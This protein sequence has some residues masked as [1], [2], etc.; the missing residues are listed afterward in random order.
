MSE[1]QTPKFLERNQTAIYMLLGLLLGIM[2]LAAG[3]TLWNRC[4]PAPRL[5]SV[6]LNGIVRDFIAETASSDLPD[7]EKRARTR[8][9]AKKLEGVLQGL[10]ERQQTIILTAPAVIAGAQDIT[11]AV[12]EGLKP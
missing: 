1:P 9:L 12:K 5:V 11:E 7:E 6:D 2:M 3:A 4:E 10:A 8:A